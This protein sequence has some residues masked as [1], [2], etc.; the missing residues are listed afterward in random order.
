MMEEHIIGYLP[1][2]TLALFLIITYIKIEKI[3]ISI[4]RTMICC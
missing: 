4:N 2:I 1:F 3:V